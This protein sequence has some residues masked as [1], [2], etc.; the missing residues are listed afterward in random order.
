MSRLIAWCAALFLTL[1]ALPGAAQAEDGYDLWLRY[2][3]LPADV[4]ARDRARATAVI[5]DADQH[6]VQ[7]LAAVNEIE[8]A[9]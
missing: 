1:G 8:R 3:P 2:R 4:Q 9:L 5:F 7:V 6:D